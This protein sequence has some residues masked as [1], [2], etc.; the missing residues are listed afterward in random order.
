MLTED[1][2]AG[3]DEDESDRLSVSL[4]LSYVTARE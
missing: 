3:V 2:P 1:G 4:I